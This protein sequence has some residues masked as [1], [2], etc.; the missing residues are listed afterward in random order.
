MSSVLSPNHPA[1]MLTPKAINIFSRLPKICGHRDGASAG[2]RGQG[3]SPSSVILKLQHSEQVIHL[4]LSFFFL[5]NGN[6]SAQLLRPT[7]VW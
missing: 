7:C 3:L 2:L 4:G 1:I 6:D 5:Q